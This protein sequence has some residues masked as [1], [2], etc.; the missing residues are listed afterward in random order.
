MNLSVRSARGLKSR[1]NNMS[2]FSRFFTIE[3]L[4]DNTMDIFQFNL[5]LFFRFHYISPV[6]RIVRLGS[7]GPSDL[8]RFR[9]A[10]RNR[11]QSM[12]TKFQ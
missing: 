2:M 10:L 5:E 7:Q 1:N 6:V 4:F 3:L 11:G 9:F 12:G 8:F